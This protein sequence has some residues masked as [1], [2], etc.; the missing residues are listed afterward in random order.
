MKRI[1]CLL[2]ALAL[3]A[4]LAACGK[5]DEAGESPALTEKPKEVAPAV[6]IPEPQAATETVEGWI[7]TEIE[8][9]DW[10]ASLSGWDTLGDTV[11]LDAET[12]DGNL[13]VAAY[14]TLS[15][16]WSRTDLDPGEALYPSIDQLEVTPETIWVLLHEGY[17]AEEMSSNNYSRELGY[18]LVRVD[19][20]TGEQNCRKLDFYSRSAFGYFSAMI[21]LDGE[22]V[23]LG[24]DGDTALLLDRDG[25]LIDRPALQLLGIAPHFRIGDRLYLDSYEGLDFLDFES[26]RTAGAPIPELKDRALYSSCL[27]NFLLLDGDDLV[28][29]DPATGETTVLFSW[30]DVALSYRHMR[31]NTGLEN[32]QGDIYHFT[33]KLIKI[34]R[35]QV[36]VKK[37]MTMVAFRAADDSLD[38]RSQRSCPDAVMD[39]IIRF[40]NTD[41]EYRVAL[42]TRVYADESEKTRLLIELGTGGGADLIDTSRLPS[43]AVD[44]QLLVDLLPYIDADE[45]VS[46]EDF[47]PS[48]FDSLL[49]KGALYEYTDKV[50][51]LTLAVPESLDSGD[52]TAENIQAQLQQHPELRPIS[53]ADQPDWLISFFAGAATAEFMD[54]Q[55]MTCDFDSP[56]FVS[57]LE[58]L[59]ELQPRVGDGSYQ[60]PWVLPLVQDLAGQ[61]GDQI[62][63]CSDG[64]YAL[65]GL[66]GSRKTGSY[67]KRLALGGWESQGTNASIGILASGPN[68]DGAWRFLRTFI[69]GE[70][71]PELRE[72][73]PLLKKS[74]EKALKNSDLTETDAEALRQLVQNSR[75]MVVT[76]EAVLTVLTTAMQSVLN[77][78]ST[79]EAV[80]AQ[81]QSRLSLYM[82][83]R[84]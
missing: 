70:A 56:V 35:G 20:A 30:L 41:P 64:D 73:I 40:N 47:L 77:G 69:Q 24:N 12:M 48:V 58:L 84:S 23:L 52:W 78:Q 75:G 9:P 10:A 8:S 33:N 27:G 15:G 43:G 14:D 45:T 18:F 50:T 71:E 31:G 76:D 62:R 28:H 63:S 53:L 36:P 80:A 59:K 68:R 17:S 83:E 2:L 42:D 34:S 46:R 6:V 82:A 55:S 21:G 5:K 66:P 49:K 57:W 72:G 67:F 7:S 25:Q 1:P 32:S 60:P 13:A 54:W 79:A 26:V 16:Q 65:P 39:A 81:V 22:R 29:F 11:Y 4:G 74:F 3:L 37:T 44:A 51:M 61:L 38:Y 19:R